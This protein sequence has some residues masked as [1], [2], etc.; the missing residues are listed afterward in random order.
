MIIRLKTEF[1]NCGPR[2][3]LPYQ[4][5]VNTAHRTVHENPLCMAVAGGTAVITNK[6]LKFKIKTANIFKVDFNPFC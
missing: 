2:T 1:N 6:A 5:S 3:V 4:S